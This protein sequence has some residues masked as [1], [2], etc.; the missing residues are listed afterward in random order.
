MRPCVIPAIEGYEPKLLGRNYGASNQV[1]LKVFTGEEAD[2]PR[3][4]FAVRALLRQQ[5][6]I[7]TLDAVDES[8]VDAE[9]NSAL[10]TVLVLSVADSVQS[11]LRDCVEGDGRAVW[12]KL[13]DKFE[14]K[15]TYNKMT[16]LKQYINLTLAE[17]LCATA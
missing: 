5:S 13:Q 11:Y 3:W 8:H 15:R 6:L 12:R 17:K 14:P 4:R 2:W 16:L 10:F 9:K 1:K 7:E